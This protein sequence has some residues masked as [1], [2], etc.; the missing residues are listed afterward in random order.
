M[1]LSGDVRRGP[2]Q[3]GG[4]ENIFNLSVRIFEIVTAPLSGNVAGGLQIGVKDCFESR[5]SWKNEFP[6]ARK[7]VELAVGGKHDQYNQSQGGEN[8]RDLIT[9]QAVDKAVSQRFDKPTK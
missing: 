1:L 8:G 4:A 5:Q 7:S 6:V 9:P 2:I 3:P